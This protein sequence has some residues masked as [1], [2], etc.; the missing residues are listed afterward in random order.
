MLVEEKSASEYI[1][2]FWDNVI[3]PAF[4]EGSLSKN[5]LLLLKE[6]LR[7]AV[8]DDLENK[9]YIP[10]PDETFKEW[11]E[12]NFLEGL[13]EYLNKNFGIEEISLE[14]VGQE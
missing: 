3:K 7:L 2:A 11:F 13:K 12:S 9:I 10:V 8:Y 5:T 1:R 6:P 14:I 4:E